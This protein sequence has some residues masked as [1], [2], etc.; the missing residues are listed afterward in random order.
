MNFEKVTKYLESL[1]E[2]FDVRCADCIVLLNHKT[3][4]RHLTGTMDFEDIKPLTKDNL[5]DIFSASKVMTMIAVMQL[6]EQG[7]IGL[8][9]ELSKYLPE[10]ENMYVTDDFDLTDFVSTG[11]FIFG[12]P[13]AKDP[14]TP[15]KNKIRIHDM[16]SMTAGLS[17]HL[18]AEQ[19]LRL[20]EENPHATTR[21]IVRTWAENPLLYEPGTRYAYSCAHDI[22]AAVVEVVSGMQFSEYMKKNV[23]E[24]AGVMK[25]MY[26]QIPDSE[27]ERLTVL[28]GFDP[29]SGKHIPQTVN[30]ARI[31]DRFESGGAGLACTVDAYS[32]VLDILANDGVAANE[33]QILKPESIDE[34]RKNRLNEQQLADFHIGGK[35]E[36]GY[37]L[38]VRTLMDTSKSKSSFGEFGWDGAAG[39]YVLA[40]PQNHLAVFYVQAAPESGSAFA[41]IHP[42][43]RDL[44]YDAIEEK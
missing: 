14:K 29:Q 31:N 8:D 22:L 32:Q 36:Y 43:L 16:M 6:V 19:T 41:T 21:E 39:A 2:E 30:A 23:F 35:N 28:Y 5:H 20:L 3:V 18:G 34:M 11:K 10:F 27:K 17:Y 44:I 15:A 37:G 40:D 12:W 26:Y 4:Y 1:R 7:A 24:P 9:D 33:T 25:D 13:S 38:G 42:T